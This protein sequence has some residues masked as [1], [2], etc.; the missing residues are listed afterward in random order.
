MQNRIYHPGPFALYILQ[1]PLRRL[2]KV[3]LQRASMAIQLI[4]PGIHPPQ[5][6]TACP[7]CLPASTL[8]ALPQSK[9]LAREKVLYYLLTQDQKLKI[10]TQIIRAFLYLPIPGPARFSYSCQSEYEPCKCV[11]RKGSKRRCV[12]RNKSSWGWLLALEPWNATAIRR[13]CPAC[14]W[15]CWNKYTVTEEAS[16]DPIF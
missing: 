11:R 16:I 10:K 8:S 9:A 2:F 13:G 7:P 3:L 4:S 15:P 12:S 1:S 5:L 14:G 6:L